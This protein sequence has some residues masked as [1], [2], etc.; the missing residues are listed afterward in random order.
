MFLGYSQL[1]KDG[2]CA[3]ALLMH[4]IRLVEWQLLSCV[5]MFFCAECALG[6]RGGREMQQCREGMASRQC[7]WIGLFFFVVA[8]LHR[9]L[10]HGW[11]STHELFLCY[12]LM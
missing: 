8:V 4:V 9:V 6:W 12:S 1:L 10:R 7:S 5:R 2:T 11:G 3:L